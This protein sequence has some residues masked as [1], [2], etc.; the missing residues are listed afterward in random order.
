MS[1]HMIVYI[2]NNE[3]KS[4]ATFKDGYVPS[5][6]D[7][8]WVKKPLITEKRLFHVEEIERQID[9]GLTVDIMTISVYGYFK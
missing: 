9:T 5:V 3:G 6:G 2:D 8:I 1:Y 7:E 4:F